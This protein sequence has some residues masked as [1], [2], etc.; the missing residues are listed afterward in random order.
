MIK[1]IL[2]KVFAALVHRKNQRW[3]RNPLLAQQKVFKQLIH[4]G[5][6]T[7]FGIDHDFEIIT[8]KTF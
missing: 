4:K 3:I 6:E 1:K 5:S 8:Y 7:K 2:A